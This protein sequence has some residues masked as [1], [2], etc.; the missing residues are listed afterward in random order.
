MSKNTI[1]KDKN[2]LNCNFPNVEDRFCPKC[3]QENIDS[4][5]SFGGIVFHFFEDLTHYDSGFFKTIKYLLFNPV[6]LT[7]EYLAGKR[8]QYVAPIKLYFFISF[9]TF[10]IPSILPPIDGKEIVKEE[11][12]YYD[13]SKTKS[14]LKNKEGISVLGSK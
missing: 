3:G 4:H 12:T 9:I 7:K 2:C 8:K 14:N 6:K 5:Q 11:K 1:R 10:L 13:E